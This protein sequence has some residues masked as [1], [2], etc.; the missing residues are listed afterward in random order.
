VRWPPRSSDVQCLLQVGP[1]PRKEWSCRAE[2]VLLQDAQA[3]NVVGCRHRGERLLTVISRLLYP[4][5]RSARGSRQRPLLPRFALL[6]M[7]RL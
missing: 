2:G 7:V 1:L 3:R 6:A 5:G 4:S